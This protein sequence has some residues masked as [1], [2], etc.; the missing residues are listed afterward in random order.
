ME[1][2]SAGNISVAGVVT[3]LLCPYLVSLISGE[4][5]SLRMYHCNSVGV[6]TRSLGR[7]SH[8]VECAKLCA[9]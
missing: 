4:R 6:R 7:V 2:L 5:I 3:V 1:W 9:P 8:F